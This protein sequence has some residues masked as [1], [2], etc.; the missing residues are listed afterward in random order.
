[1]FSTTDWRGVPTISFPA[2]PPSMRRKQ[3][4]TITIVKTKVT[5]YY[6]FN[7]MIVKLRWKLLFIDNGKYSHVVGDQVRNASWCEKR[8][9]FSE[10]EESD[11]LLLLSN[12]QA[13]F[14][15]KHWLSPKTEDIRQE[16]KI[17]VLMSK[18]EH[19]Y[20]NHKSGLYQ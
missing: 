6:S 13:N 15:I 8:T 14:Q 19:Y 20:Q 10:K 17:K 5:I 4:L 16:I 9:W 2:M 7:V 11:K 3:V 12:I 18:A 1:L